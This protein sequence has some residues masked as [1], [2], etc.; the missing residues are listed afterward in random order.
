MSSRPTLKLQART[1]PPREGMVL[2]TPQEERQQSLVN[3][4]ISNSGKPAPEGV[5]KPK[6]V[7]EA[8]HAQQQVPTHQSNSQQQ[9]RFSGGNSGERRQTGRGHSDGL[10]NGETQSNS[11]S[12]SLGPDQRRD[13]SAFS[14]DN[15]SGVPSSIGLRVPTREFPRPDSI[16]VGS[17]REFLRSNEISTSNQLM[18]SDS[19]RDFGGF[20]ASLGPPIGGRNGSDGTSVAYAEDPD[21]RF[22]RAAKD[23]K[24]QVLPP[25]ET[26]EIGQWGPSDLNGFNG[27]PG[28]GF[29][30]EQGF[31]RGLSNAQGQGGPFS[32]G[33]GG[34]GQFGMGQSQQ[35][36]W[37]NGP[38]NGPF[39]GPVSGGEGGFPVVGSGHNFGGG[40]YGGG[41][42]RSS[43]ESRGGMGTGE[44]GG[45]YGDSRGNNAVFGGMRRPGEDRS[46]RINPSGKSKEISVQTRYQQ[47]LIDLIAK[48]EKDSLGVSQDGRPRL[49]LTRGG[50]PIDPGNNTSGGQGSQS[51]G[52]SGSASG[53]SVVGQGRSGSQAEHEQ[54]SSAANLAV[55]AAA[56][57]GDEIALAT[58]KTNLVRVI[59]DFMA[60]FG[61]DAAKRSAKELAGLS[62]GDKNKL[63]YSI[64][65][66]A[67][68]AFKFE[69]PGE[70]QQLA[71]LAVALLTGTKKEPAGASVEDVAE[72]L[73]QAL[74]RSASIDQVDTSDVLSQSLLKQRF[75]TFLEE[76]VKSKGGLPE[77]KLGPLAK[78]VF[79][80]KPQPAV[81]STEE[82][83]NADV[84]VT[85]A[86]LPVIITPAPRLTQDE[87][88]AALEDV[89]L[90][91]IRVLSSGLIGSEIV[92]IAR[93]AFSKYS[94]ADAASAL[95]DEILKVSTRIMFV[96]FISFFRITLVLLIAFE[97]LL[98]PA[99]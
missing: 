59:E 4:S 90:V 17:T 69:A 31:D 34:G 33:G 12:S 94:K 3:S 58:L 57:F 40:N 63:C 29:G 28:G 93:D 1:L 65:I 56:T 35:R 62:G 13:F 60:A 23:A 16:P 91:A 78:A 46:E 47:N 10:N 66:L 97:L 51:T 84:E 14:R 24:Q 68:H 79:A 52:P 73:E 21:N 53:T 81:E 7:E 64:Y 19:T 5:W 50:A 11:H 92:S 41:G 42:G 27:S 26:R 61:K 95:V 82:S 6:R 71:G 74:E 70:R 75:F 72:G 20:A 48:P 83:E 49:A 37:N 44:R 8:Q 9:H 55:K 15:D 25:S 43:N 32:S 38:N 54:S 85:K 80:E 98:N 67:D 18:P 89:K 96:F 88:Y 2:P 39:G 22:L 76:L 36:G 86:S 30:G 45:N 99:L 77:A 87:M